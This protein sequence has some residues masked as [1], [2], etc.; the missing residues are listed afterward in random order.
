MLT[1]YNLNEENCL[2][3]DRGQSEKLQHTTTKNYN[4]LQQKTTTHY[5]TTL[6]HTTTENNNALTKHRNWKVIIAIS[7][8]I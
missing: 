6:Q 3:L 7:V 4:T 8:L 1:T 5:N 2:A